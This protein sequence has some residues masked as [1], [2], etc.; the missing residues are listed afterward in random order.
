[1][2]VLLQKLIC[3][4]IPVWKQQIEGGYRLHENT[5]W[6]NRSGNRVIMKLLHDRSLR[7]DL[8]LS[9]SR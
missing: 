2:P 9:T 5:W 1:M 3:V 6:K 8:L 7:I 4:G